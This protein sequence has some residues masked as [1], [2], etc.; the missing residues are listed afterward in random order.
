MKTA[1]LHPG[2]PSMKFAHLQYTSI[3]QGIG[4]VRSVQKDPCFSAK[5]ENVCIILAI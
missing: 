2:K 4:Q 1:H 3:T 5:V